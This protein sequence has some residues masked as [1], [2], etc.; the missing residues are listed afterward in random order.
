[1]GVRGEIGG[2]PELLVTS[3]ATVVVLLGRPFPLGTNAFMW[4]VAVNA[5]EGRSRRAVGILG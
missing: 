2:F 4:I 1:M 5:G 3:E